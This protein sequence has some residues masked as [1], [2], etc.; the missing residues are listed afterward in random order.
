MH[1]QPQ[2]I[3]KDGHLP[4]KRKAQ[5]ERVLVVGNHLDLAVVGEEADQHRAFCLALDFGP[6]LANQPI[7]HFERGQL[8]LGPIFVGVVVYAH[9]VDG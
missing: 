3:E 4:I 2:R 6:Q 9:K 7:H 5:F 1:I 8:R